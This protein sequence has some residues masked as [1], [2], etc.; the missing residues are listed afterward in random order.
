M[1]AIFITQNKQ[2][3]LANLL[4][5]SGV[6]LCAFYGD[7]IF[8]QANLPLVVKRLRLLFTKINTHGF[9]T[10]CAKVKHPPLAH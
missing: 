5:F 6:T 2:T 8:A 9:L 1:Q 4:C 7:A 3:L 10:Y